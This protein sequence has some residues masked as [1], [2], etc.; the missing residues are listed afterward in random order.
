[1]RTKVTDSTG[2]EFSSIKE[3]CKEHNKTYGKVRKDIRTGT[4]R[5][6]IEKVTRTVDHN[7]N[8]FYS[9]SEM[10]LYYKISIDVFRR[11]MRESDGDLRYALSKEGIRD[12]RVQDHLGNEYASFFDMCKA[13]GSTDKTVDVRLRK[14]WSLED[15]LTRKVQARKGYEIEDSD[16]RKFMS[17][18]E[19]CR[20]HKLSYASISRSIRNG[21]TLED[22]ENTR[23][24]LKEKRTDHLGNE[25]KNMDEMCR[26]WGIPR[27]TYC[28]RKG[29]GWSKEK[30]LTTPIKNGKADKGEGLWKDTKEYI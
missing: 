11:K 12:R 7:G 16:G 14:G 9:I 3:F 10:L 4:V 15:A 19:Y 24:G 21:K 13:Y 6:D 5:D 29:L 30:A 28:G 8:E 23:L 26:H 20:F 27:D 18:A 25:F 1:M 2:K 22:I 17:V